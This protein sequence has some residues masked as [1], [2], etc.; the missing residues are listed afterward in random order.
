MYFLLPF[1]FIHYNCNPTVIAGHEKSVFRLIT[2][3]LSTEI[4]SKRRKICAFHEEKPEHQ[5]S[6]TVIFQFINQPNLSIE[7]KSFRL[8]FCHR[9]WSIKNLSFFNR[10]HEISSQTQFF[11][12]VCD[13]NGLRSTI[14]LQTNFLSNVASLIP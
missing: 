13:Q 7:G 11:T 8:L 5:Q 2:L 3:L 1:N 10:Y 9:N 6:F 4:F 12:Q 14:L